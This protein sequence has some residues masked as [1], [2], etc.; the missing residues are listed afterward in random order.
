LQLNALVLVAC[1][2]SCWNILSNIN[3]NSNIFLDQEN[4][5]LRDLHVLPRRQFHN[6]KPIH[7]CGVVLYRQHIDEL[8]FRFVMIHDYPSPRH[9]E[10]GTTLPLEG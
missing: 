4:F 7:V 3:L 5:R 9:R 1:W 2:N 8:P 10:N 6:A